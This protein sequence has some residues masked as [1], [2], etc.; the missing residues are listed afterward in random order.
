MFETFQKGGFLTELWDNIS[1]LPHQKSLAQEQKELTGKVQNELAEVTF[2]DFEVGYVQTFDVGAPVPPC[3]MYE[4][5]YRKD[6]IRTAI[7]IEVS[8]FYKLF[9]LAM[10]N[11][12]GKRELPDHLIPELEFLHFLTFREAQARKDENQES[13]KSCLYAQKD[14]LERHLALWVPKFSSELQRK[15]S[16]PFYGHLAGITSMFIQRDLDWVI[17]NLEDERFN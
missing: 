2:G 7:M 8:E 15:S 17:S 6:E 16:V 14:F 4:G 10:N 9:G 12:E 3:P 5:S 13:L 1:A 11:E